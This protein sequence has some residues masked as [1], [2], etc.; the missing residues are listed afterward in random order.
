MHRR[1]FISWALAGVAACLGLRRRPRAELW[2]VDKRPGSRPG[3]RKFELKPVIA[4][5]GSSSDPNITIQWIG[6]RK[7]SD[8]LYHA[9]KLGGLAE[10]KDGDCV[11]ALVNVPPKTAR[12]WWRGEQASQIME[13]PMTDGPRCFDF[14]TTCI[15]NGHDDLPWLIYADWLDERGNDKL[16][17]LCRGRKWQRWQRLVRRHYDEERLG[18]AVFMTPSGREW[19]RQWILR[20]NDELGRDASVVFGKVYVFRKSIRCIPEPMPVFMVSSWRDYSAQYTN[21]S[22]ED[23]AQ[24]LANAI[25]QVHFSPPVELEELVGGGGSRH[26]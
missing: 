2:A 8:G 20:T 5:Y 21:V 13:G 22:Q 6:W 23:F 24:R 16:A 26:E 17:S 15:Y 14:E 25:D 9:H 1:N 10:A 19:V 7:E 12:S 11:E 3:L 18:D 4:T